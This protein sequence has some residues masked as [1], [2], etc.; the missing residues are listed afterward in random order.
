MN[1]GLIFANKFQPFSKVKVTAPPREELGCVSLKPLEVAPRGLEGK[2]TQ[3]T[4]LKFKSQLK[5]T[6]M[7]MDFLDLVIY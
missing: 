7:K 1:F 6:T 2:G 5:K 3:G 4:A